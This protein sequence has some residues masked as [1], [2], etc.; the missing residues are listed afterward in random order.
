MNTKTQITIVEFAEELNLMRF[1]EATTA[2]PL[3]A[4]K[5]YLSD[6]NIEYEND[7]IQVDNGEYWIDD[8]AQAYIT[9]IEN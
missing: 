3:E 2:T 6:H 9:Y 7:D 5:R 1:Y 4:L 8:V